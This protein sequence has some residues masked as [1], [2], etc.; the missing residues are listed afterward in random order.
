MTG[1]VTRTIGAAVLGLLAGCVTASADAPPGAGPPPVADAEI[2]YETGPCFGTCPVYALTIRPDGTARF[3]GKRFTA[4]TGTR[5][6]TVGA[7]AYRAFAARLAPYRP[8]GGEQLYQPGTPLCG[9]AATDMPS[10]DVVWH[11]ASGA[12]Q[13]LNYYYGCRMEGNDAMRSA[14]R[15][16]PDLLPIGELVGKR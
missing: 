1:A 12:V 8:E 14:L 3:E 11:A 10:V 2:R 15:D 7:D 4:V 9:P 6:L 5:D 13:H 16:A